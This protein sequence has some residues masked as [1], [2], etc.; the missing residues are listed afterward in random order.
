MIKHMMKNKIPNIGLA[1]NKE[2]RKKY[3][4][5]SSELSRLKTFANFTW[6]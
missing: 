6:Q 1:C 2:V 3:N 4:T 5:P